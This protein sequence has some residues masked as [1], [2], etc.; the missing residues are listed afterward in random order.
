MDKDSK[1]PSS[2]GFI[3][4]RDTSRAIADTGSY[5]QL[6][7]KLR[8]ILPVVVL[9]VFAVLFIW[10]MVRSHSLTSVVSKAIPNLVIENLR[11]TGR[12]AGD[13]PYMLMAKKA[14]QVPLSKSVMDLDKPEGDITLSGGAWMAGKADYGRYDQNNKLLWLGGGVQFFHDNGYQFNTSEANFDINR[15]N[16][17]GSQPVLIQGNFG[18]ITGDGFRMLDGGKVVVITGHAKA[19]LNLQPSSSS[20]TKGP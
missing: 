18:E 10:P 20:G 6:I 14:L 11:L 19:L 17:W 9:G 12:S 8:W 13:E 15:N 7:G 5:S 1:N 2:Q 16:A 4:M 3:R